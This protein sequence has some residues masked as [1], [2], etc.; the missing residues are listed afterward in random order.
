MLGFHNYFASDNLNYS[1]HS[2]LY[3]ASPTG[4]LALEAWQQSP[5]FKS[6]CHQKNPTPWGHPVI[7]DPIFGL[8]NEEFYWIRALVA[9][10][11]GKGRHWHC[12]VFTDNSSFPCL[13]HW[14]L[15]YSH[16]DSTALWKPYWKL[17]HKIYGFVTRLAKRDI[18]HTDTCF[19]SRMVANYLFCTQSPLLINVPL[20]CPAHA[21]EAAYSACCCRSVMQL[22]PVNQETDDSGQLS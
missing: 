15:D 4:A 19:Q 1:T 14:H 8:N 17:K 21:C 2:W 12:Y 10:S 7:Q 5:C 20:L 22:S 3:G 13:W 16:A 18:S 9:G 6:P 11:L